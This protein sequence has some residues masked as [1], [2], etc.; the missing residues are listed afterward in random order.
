MFAL[1]FAA[2]SFGTVIGI[3]WSLIAMAFVGY[4]Q[5]ELNRATGQRPAARAS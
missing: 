1:A 5:R 3:V 4:I 2:V